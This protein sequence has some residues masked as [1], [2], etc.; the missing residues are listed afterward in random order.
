[1]WGGRRG[2]QLFSNHTV[3]CNHSAQS[4]CSNNPTP[5]QSGSATTL[6]TNSSVD[7]KTMTAQPHLLLASVRAALADDEAPKASVSRR[8]IHLTLLIV[9]PF[10]HLPP[11]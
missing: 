11:H 5:R 1:M 6:D 2:H 10:C 4:P 3:R 9:S 7:D 8:P